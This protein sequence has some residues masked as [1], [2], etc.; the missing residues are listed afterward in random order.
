MAKSHH[1]SGIEIPIGVSRAAEQLTS[2]LRK[3]KL[4]A[5]SIDASKP[6]FNG[7]AL[8]WEKACVIVVNQVAPNWYD[9]EPFDHMN[10]LL[11]L[12][13]IIT[14]NGPNRSWIEFSDPAELA[15]VMAD[16]TLT[17]PAQKLRSMLFKTLLEI[18]RNT[19]QKRQE[20]I[21]EQT[22]SYA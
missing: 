17:V 10:R 4:D 13:L 6:R 8:L 9:S 2:L 11:P 3:K 21:H 1:P 20:T 15:V 14:E 12:H 5:Q 19:F 7:R 16:H 18:S 22:E